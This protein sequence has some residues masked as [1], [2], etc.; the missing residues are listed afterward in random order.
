MTS[1]RRRNV[2][3][4]LR[5]LMP[6]VEE[7]LLRLAEDNAPTSEHGLDEVMAAFMAGARDTE[8][9]ALARRVLSEHRVFFD[10]TGD[11]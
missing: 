1:E 6:E 5:G 2:P 8:T 10:M 4:T 11:R 7:R 9:R 3:M